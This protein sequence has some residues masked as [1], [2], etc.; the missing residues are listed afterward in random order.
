MSNKL[1]DIV[2]IILSVIAVLMLAMTVLLVNNH[3]RDLTTTCE[4]LKAQ[5]GG[6]TYVPLP[7]RCE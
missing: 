7:K 2:L 6:T 4:K 1:D 3:E 5:Q